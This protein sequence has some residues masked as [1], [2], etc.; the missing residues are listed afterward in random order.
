MSKKKIKKLLSFFLDAKLF[1]NLC[2]VKVRLK[3]FKE[4]CNTINIII[5]LNL[6]ENFEAKF[7][8]HKN[9]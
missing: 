8:V 7:L 1:L 3:S 6:L 9:F 4:W 2:K 5:E